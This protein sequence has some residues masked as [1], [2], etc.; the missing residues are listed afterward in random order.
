MFFKLPR[1]DN[2]DDEN[3]YSD[4]EYRKSIFAVGGLVVIRTV[5]LVLTAVGSVYFAGDVGRHAGW[6]HGL[7]VGCWSI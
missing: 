5:I 7:G 1:K 3:R 6:L 2:E 4:N